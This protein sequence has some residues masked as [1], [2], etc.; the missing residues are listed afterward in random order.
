MDWGS[1]E[2]S[3]PRAIGLV[4]KRAAAHRLVVWLTGLAGFLRRRRFGDALHERMESA[5]PFTTSS[6]N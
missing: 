3:F 5:G 1:S 2:K 4:L 6:T